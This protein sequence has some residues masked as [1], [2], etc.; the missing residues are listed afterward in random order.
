MLHL[1][2]EA[3]FGIYHKM[4]MCIENSKRKYKH[5]EAVTQTY[6]PRILQFTFS[7]GS[8][9]FGVYGTST[10]G[11]ERLAKPHLYT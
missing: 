4:K 6:W 7:A 5:E 9:L 3:T 11:P 10:D 2:S 8:V 1:Q